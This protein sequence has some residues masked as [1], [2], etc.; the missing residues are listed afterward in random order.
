MVETVEVAII[1]LK[2]AC[3]RAARMERRIRI[4]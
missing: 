1:K 3:E 4:A 2:F